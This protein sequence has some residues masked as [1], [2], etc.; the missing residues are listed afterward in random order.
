MVVIRLIQEVDLHEVE[1][2]VVDLQVVDCQ[3]EQ[4]LRRYPM[5][6]NRPVVI[7]S[8]E[9]KVERHQENHYPQVL[10]VSLASRKVATS[11]PEGLAKD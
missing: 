5:V 8:V 4:N 3:V 6:W 11:H 2:Q 1:L 10:V 9:V 7:H